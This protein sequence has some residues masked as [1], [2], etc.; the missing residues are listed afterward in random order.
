MTLSNWQFRAIFASALNDMPR[1]RP[2]EL[3]ST[4]PR[5]GPQ[6]SL[7]PALADV[8]IQSRQVIVGRQLNQKRLE[9]QAQVA[10]AR[11]R[12]R[13]KRQIEQLTMAC[14][15]A[16][17]AAEKTLR[18][19][20]EAAAQK[21]AQVRRLN[22]LRVAVEAGDEVE[23]TNSEVTQLRKFAGFG[24]KK[25][26][27]SAVDHQVILQ[28]AG[29]ETN[30]AIAA[31]IGVAPST[32]LRHLKNRPP[33]SEKRG[34]KPR[35]TPEMLSAAARFQF[36]C[37][38]ACLRRTGAF[39]R[40]AFG[41]SVCPRTI[42]RHLKGVAGF[43]LGDFRRFPRDRN[44]DHAIQARFD[45]ATAMVNKFGQNTLY[46]AIY[47]DEMKL[48]RTTKRK[49]WSIAGWIP[50]VTDE[51]YSENP[52]HISLLYAASPAFGTLYF[53]VIEGSVTGETCLEFLQ[54]MVASYVRKFPSDRKRAFIMDNAKIHHRGIV[55]AY[56]YGEVVSQRIGLEFLPIY[57]PFLNPLEETFALIKTR[58]WRERSNAT[59][60]GE[61]KAML[62]RDLSNQVLA[63]TEHDVR[64]YYFHVEHFLK[65]ATE[66]T[67]VFTQ[68]L[69]ESSHS[70]DEMGLCPM[71]P[72][73][74]EALLDSYLPHTYEE[75]TP[76]M[77]DSI[78]RAF[79]CQRLTMDAVDALLPRS[80][81]DSELAGGDDFNSERE[82]QF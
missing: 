34:R 9:K 53:E 31:R 22:Q 17:L 12:Q 47:F 36:I 14:R 19:Y 52:E 67:P 8:N 59:V 1:G 58:L 4:L 20:E 76:E 82:F 7:D 32:V 79:G 3:P 61:S 41:V 25:P 51:F 26:R 63:I 16:Q 54:G 55:T 29:T 73:T 24:T 71:L 62:K 6:V 68:Q 77:N 33:A 72:E 43:R 57:S 70:G 2:R 48:T 75:F 13:A 5:L 23:L 69:Y 74:V 64:Q 46:E 21:E 45:Y 60:T 40:L 11:A 39:L 37:N 18:R 10:R 66:R 81:D 28:L 42:S 56:L 27:L 65:F 78:E 38:T 50:T 15:H 44:A 80:S 30:A 49:A 35:L